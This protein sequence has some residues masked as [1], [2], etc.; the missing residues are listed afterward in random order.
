ML[1]DRTALIWPSS[2]SRSAKKNLS[3][4]TNGTRLLVGVDGRS[5]QGR[6]YRDLVASYGRDLGG[7]DQLSE[8]AKGLVRTCAALSARAEH[9]QAVVVRGD[10]VDDEQLTRLLNSQT[11]A[12]KA[13]GTLASRRAKPDVAEPSLRERLAAREAE[14]KQ[15]ST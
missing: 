5:E 14:A 11:R 13:L 8:A 7:F 3:K 10:P 4:V 15:V 9:M 12:L 1:A 6:R 2:R